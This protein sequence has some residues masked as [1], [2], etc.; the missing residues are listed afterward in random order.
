MRYRRLQVHY[1]MVAPP[2]PAWPFD[3]WW[4]TDRLRILV[5]ACW[6]PDADLY[7]SATALEVTVALAGVDEDDI[8]IQLFD[9]VLVVEGHRRLASAPPEALYHV[10][11]I[12]QG[13]FHVALSLPARIDPEHVEARADRGLLRIT[14]PKRGD[15]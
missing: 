13:A 11:G 4:P 7:E 14:L 15:G 10:A 9:D 2:G 1:A 8:D 6:R 12:R 5:Q 3:E